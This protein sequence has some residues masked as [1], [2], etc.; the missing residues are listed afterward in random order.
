MIRKAG[1]TMI[2]KMKSSKKFTVVSK[3]L[4]LEFVESKTPAPRKAYGWKALAPEVRASARRGMP[5]ITKLF[6]AFVAVAALAIPAALIGQGLDPGLLLKPATDSWP[7]YSG[8]YSGQRYSTLN[9]I[10]KTTVKD[11]SLAWVG[12]VTAGEGGGGFGRGGG[13]NAPTTVGGEAPENANTAALGGGTPRVG[14]AILQVNGV[15]YFST[16]DNAWAM[17]A[18]DGTVLWHYFWRTKGGTHIGNRGMAMSG[19]WLYFETPD[20]YLISLDAKTGKERWHKEISD[21]TEQYFSTMSPVLIG[22]HLLVGTG[23]DLDSPGFLQSFD[24]ETGELQWKHYTVPMQKGDAGLDTWPSLDAASH[25]GAQVWTVGAYDPDT[26]LYIFGT[27]NPTPAYTPQTREG[28]NLFT[29]TLM[30]VNVDTGKMAWY[31][32]TSPHDTHDWDSTQTPILVDGTWEGKPRKLVLQATRN[33]YFFVLDRVTGEHLFTSK[34]G[35][36]ANWSKPLNA[37][38]QPYPNPEKDSTVPGSLVS[39]SNGGITNWPPAAFSPQ[40]GLFYV[41]EHDSYSMYYLTETDPRGAM[42]LGGKEEDGVGSTGNY[43]D[44]IDY[45]TGK[46]AWRHEFPAGA[47]GAGGGTGLL[48]TA[49]GI[50]FGGD[51]G[52]NF[53]AY[54]AS[55]GHPLWHSHI[56]GVSNAP[57]TYLLD[58]HQNVIVAAGDSIYCFV[59]N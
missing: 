14:G 4:S 24:P 19:D 33:G 40:T 49:G 22:N 47:A 34:F 54:D 13:G 16:P 50:L 25:G 6:L 51:E 1:T 21:F 46:F 15:L 30:A 8:D 58:G 36:S 29:C 44:A 48:V 59:L 20:D 27:G 43:I 28:D 31:Y 56:G 5:A 55:T 52:G 53:V 32:Q 38:G 39:P 10:S 42:G 12:H 11:L 23:D 35:E 18:R 2:K 3:T 7:T 37:K 9:E 26:K 17:D 41:P 57:E 45:H